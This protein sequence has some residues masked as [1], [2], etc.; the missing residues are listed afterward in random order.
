MEYEEVVICQS[1]LR[2]TCGCLGVVHRRIGKP[3]LAS[4]F[5]VGLHAT[6]FVPGQ[7]TVEGDEDQSKDK[8][9]NNANPSGLN[10]VLSDIINDGHVHIVAE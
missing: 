10:Q 1:H 3:G 8:E 7:K 6:P 4:V 2:N 5:Q 9:Q